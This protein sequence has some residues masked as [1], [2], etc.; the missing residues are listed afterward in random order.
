MIF[1]SFQRAVSNRLPHSHCRRCP[2]WERIGWTRAILLSQWGG[3]GISPRGCSCGRHQQLSH[4]KSLSGRYP[5]TVQLCWRPTLSI[6]SFLSVLLLTPHIRALPSSPYIL[7][8]LTI[9]A[10]LPHPL[11][12]KPLEYCTSFTS[13]CH[14]FRLYLFLW[15][16]SSPSQLSSSTIPHITIPSTQFS[17]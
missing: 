3:K 6:D 8:I 5:G 11:P 9:L 7:T 4:R 10:P 13:S 17:R 1:L 2:T 12:P 14:I 15:G 16:S